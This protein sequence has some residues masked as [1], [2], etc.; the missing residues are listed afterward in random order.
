MHYSLRGEIWHAMSLVSIDLPNRWH[1]GKRHAALLKVQDCCSHGQH[2]AHDAGTAFV[3][4][5]DAS[6]NCGD[7]VAWCVFQEQRSI[8]IRY[9]NIF[10]LY[11]FVCLILFKHIRWPGAKSA[12][13]VAALSSLLLRE[14]P[15]FTGFLCQPCVIQEKRWRWEF[16][17][18]TFHLHIRK[19]S[20][21][22]G[23]KKTHC[24][25]SYKDRVAG[26]LKWGA[27]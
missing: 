16:L 22:Q 18:S 3:A 24:G 7:Q 9:C 8:D 6:T 14:P 23:L 2:F 10:M 20:W 1:T 5:Q 11:N 17:C 12:R 26:S 27:L 19:P 25:P 21:A 4:L 13:H 15:F